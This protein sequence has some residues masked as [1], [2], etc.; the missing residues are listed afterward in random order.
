M[1]IVTLYAVH[2]G[3]D[4]RHWGHPAW[5]FRTSSEAEHAAKGQG[6]YGGTAPTSEVRAIKLEDDQ[7]L[8]L[9]SED[10]IRLGGPEDE[11]K[12]RDKALAKL[13][14]LEKRILGI[15]DKVS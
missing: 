10:R 15:S 14:D 6:W 1:D 9:R 13:T 3:D 8:I 11:K 5:Y 7:Y 12:I 4:D 2:Q